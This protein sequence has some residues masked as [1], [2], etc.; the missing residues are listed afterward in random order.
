MCLCEVNYNER[1]AMST[2]TTFFNSL[3]SHGFVVIL[4]KTLGR[5][6]GKRVLVEGVD[7][8]FPIESTPDLSMPTLSDVE[9]CHSGY[10]KWKHV[11]PLPNQRMML[12]I[13]AQTTENFFVVADAWAQ[14]LS[15]FILPGSH[16]LDIGCGCGRTARILTNNQN[17][18]R[19]TGFD[20]IE[21][22]ILWCNRYFGEIYH[23]RFRFY[24]LD[25]R[26]A[27]YNPEGKLTC[28]TAKF[29]AK[30]SAVDFLYAASL[31]THLMPDD[32]RSYAA[33][34][35]RVLTV[36]G[37]ALVSIHDQPGHEK[38]F[39]GSED[40]AD[41]DSEYFESIMNEMGFEIEEDIGDLCGQ[42]TFL[43]RKVA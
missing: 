23:D 19:Y 32:L 22:Y 39:T 33:E 7:L 11:L 5:I 41:Y 1:E 43:M 15:R 40:R 17:V 10:A 2:D 12:H 8:D 31:F 28:K 38:K 34:M 25:V 14:V 30:S 24:H 3:K 20:V 21:P 4:V 29:P 6:M 35:Y 18:E 42:R 36:E 13:G 16:V 37:L 27:R 9:Q 26:T